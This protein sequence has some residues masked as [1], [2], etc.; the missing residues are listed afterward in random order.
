MDGADPKGPPPDAEATLSLAHALRT[1]LTSLS[2]GL[3]LLDEGALGAL[4]DAQ[5]EIVR[6]LIDDVARL[7]LL[8]D[9]TLQTDRLGAY[10]GPVERAPIDLGEL[11]RSAAAPIVEQAREKDVRVV[12]GLPE[13]ITV[14]ADPVKLGWVASSL[15]GNALRY[16]P[17]GATIDVQ[18]RDAEQAEL[19]ISDQGPGVP[20][21]ARD[22]IFDRKGGRGLFLAREIVEA[23]GGDIRISSE[24]GRGCSFIISLP[25]VR[26]RRW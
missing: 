24:V 22:R 3:G 2:L 26:S 25:V 10:A 5:L 9:R 7:S 11:V 4:S 13:G 18:L 16:S 1:P 6:A 19:Q 12:L 8:V 20:P 17:S 21:S 23:H 14:V 15:M